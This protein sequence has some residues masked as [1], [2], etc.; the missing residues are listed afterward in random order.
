MTKI[1]IT[2]R[3]KNLGIGW[4]NTPARDGRITPPEGPSVVGSIRDVSAEYNRARRLH[5]GGVHW[6]AAFYVGGVRVQAEDFL[7]AMSDLLAPGLK[8]DWG[9]TPRYLADEA[10]V[11]AVS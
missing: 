1:T 9:H 4:S 6:T 2:R 5:S 10:T 7:R 8:D 11:E 3:S